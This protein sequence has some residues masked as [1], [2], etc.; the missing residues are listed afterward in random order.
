MAD[1]QLD[2]ADLTGVATVRHVGRIV[3]AFGTTIQISGLP[4]NIG[5][6]CRLYDPDSDWRMTAEVIGI[7]GRGAVLQPFGHLR[8]LS[9]RAR[10]EA[11]GRDDTVRV[12]DAL[13]GRVVDAF[14]KPIDGGESPRLSNAVVVRRAPPPPMQ[15]PPIGSPIETGVRA[16]DSLLT[17]GRGQRMGI[18][19]PAGSGKSTL[20]GML[21]THSAADVNVIA[22]IGERGR[23]VREFIEAN[24]ADCL[25]RTVVVVATSD[26]PSLMR[27]RAAQTATAIAEYFRDQG[28][29][30]QLLADSLTRYARALR[31][32]G[33]AT[34]EV[35][36]RNDFPPSVLSELPQLLERAGTDG[37]GSI[38]AFYTMLIEAED[39]IDPIAEETMSILDGHIVL[40]RKLA[41]QGHY[42]AIDILTSVSRLMP[43][44][45]T[46]DH[47]QRA[48]RAR[49][50]ISR[51]R[52]LELLVQMGEYEPGRDAE[53][54]A[55]ITSQPG[56][57][58]HVR[59]A[60][61]ETSSFDDSVTSL[62]E[63]TN[64]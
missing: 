5:Q 26:E 3:D 28:L 54:D 1:P 31:D 58:R 62:T 10:V 38:T 39:D 7:N 27:A 45:V 41:M 43:Q 48:E 40:S 35:A 15:R 17:C 8:G 55:A 6:T 9:S 24:L 46:A 64:G 49:E 11:L 16:I 36:T 53:A 25:H 2:L 57:I 60:L 19:A 34:G 13:L 50:L 21:A 23:E 33:L 61:D 12:D 29:H 59:Q 37:T 51:H 52:D 14:G 42:P 18:F 22:L 20:L 63:A 56:L 47:R 32:I 30:V 4:V 44:L